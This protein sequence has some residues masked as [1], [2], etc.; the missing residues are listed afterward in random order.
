MKRRQNTTPKDKSFDEKKL[1]RRLLINAEFDS[2]RFRDLRRSAAFYAMGGATLLEIADV[3][4]HGT[5]A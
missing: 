1:W 2:L 4:W 3:L 5:S